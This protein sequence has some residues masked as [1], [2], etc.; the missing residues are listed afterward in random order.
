M[1][2]YKILLTFLIVFLL[3]GTSAV[4][5]WPI[6]QEG[7][8]ATETYTWDAI[9]GVDQLGRNLPI[10]SEVGNPKS[11]RY[12]GMFY[13]LAS[14]IDSG[15]YNIEYIS[16]KYPSAIYNNTDGVWN[17][18]CGHH[19]GEP[20]FG[21]YQ[22]DDTWVIR[23]HM[24]MLASAGVDFIVFDTTNGRTFDGAVKR[25]LEI[26][27]ELHQQGVK[28]PKI[29][30]Y[31]NYQSGIIMDDLYKRYYDANAPARYPDLW[32]YW[33]DKPLIIGQKTEASATV[34][35]FFTVKQSQW[36]NLP[37]EEDGFPWIEFSRD[38]PVHTYNGQPEVMS[39][40]VAQNATFY[41]SDPAFF[42][43]T[44]TWGRSYHDGTYDNTP[45]AVNYGYNFAEQWNQA[46]EEDPPIVFVTQWNEWSAGV[47]DN[48]FT[49]DHYANFYDNCT[50]EYSRDIEPMKDG[51]MDN[52]Y[53]Q[54]A[55]YIR[56]YKGF[57]AMPVP[58]V[59]KT[60]TVGTDFSQWADVSPAYKDYTGDTAARDS[61]GTGAQYY[62]NNTGR[63]DIDVMKVARDAN[64]IY[65][66]V[67]TV[68]SITPYTDA[69]WMRLLI[70][71]DNNPYNGW[72][73][74]DYII[75]RS[76]VGANT[77]ILEQS[78]GGW[79]W[80]TVA[81]NISY[82]VVGNQMQLAIPRSSLGISGDPLNI[83]FKWS[84]NMQSDGDIMDFYANGD[85]APDG[86][87]RYAYY[88]SESTLALP[89]P[90]T[91]PMPSP[92]P[93][94]TLAPIPGVE[95]SW[96]FNNTGDL[97]AW[98]KDEYDVDF[99]NPSASTSTVAIGSTDIAAEK[100]TTTNYFRDFRVFVTSNGNN[101][102]N[103]KLTLYKWNTDYNTTISG[104][105]ITYWTWK[106]FTDNTWISVPWEGQEP[107]DYLWTLS[108]AVENVGVWKAGGSYPGVT[109]YFNGTPV[110]GHY[111]FAITDSNVAHFG[112]NA[113]NA[114]QGSISN[115]NSSIVYKNKINMELTK[116]QKIEIRM[117]NNTSSTSAQLYFNT[118]LGKLVNTWQFVTE[119][120]NWTANGHV[121]GFGWQ[122]GGCIGGNVVGVDPRI[123]SPDNLGTDITNNK[124]VR[125]K[126]K[127]S[128][129]NTTGQ[130]YFTTTGDTAWNEVKSK[131]FT[132]IANDAN[133]TEY[134]IDMST[135]P[136]WTGTL[137]Q[138]WL[139]PNKDVTTGSFSI[140]SISIQKA[141][142]KDWL[143]ASN[144]ENW[145]T[146]T[147]ISGFGWQTGGYVVGN[148]TGGDPAMFSSDNLGIDLTTNKII[149]IKLKNSTSST[150][151]QI[152]FTTNTDNSFSETKS[153]TFTIIANDSQYTEYLVDM[154]FVPGWRGTL[155]QVRFD[156]A[157]DASN[158]SFSLDY[159]E[160]DEP[161]DDTYSKVFTINSNDPN[162]TTYLVDMS[163]VP[164]WTGTLQGLKLKPAVGATSGTF[165]IDYIR[166]RVIPSN[167]SY[168]WEF[169]S[170]TQGWSYHPDI[171]GFGWQTGGY[172]GGDIVG[173]DP[174]MF[175]PDN[176]GTD[177]TDNKLITVRMKNNTSSTTGQ[178]YFITNS[179]PNYNQVMTKTFTIVA[180]DT[181]YRDYII[182]MSNIPGWGGTL[183][184]LRLDPDMNVTSG[185]FSVDYI[186]IGR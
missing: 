100:F 154:S 160:I 13:Y 164:G 143:Y 124:L 175:S 21:F 26:L 90:T 125:V 156:P 102:G 167:T 37:I 149:R 180:N 41:M 84:D 151:G 83:E 85:C 88:T 148:I 171:S 5:N 44:G 133:Y 179:V 157:K 20:L 6:G 50:Q 183:K 104:M 110:S 117:K 153:K 12:V 137:K 147:N 141:A 165:C 18:G 4:T 176:V 142:T 52:Y 78:T 140:D 36:P 48:Y 22:P 53:M 65:F 95:K 112:V 108:G 45:G 25:I 28:V 93:T 89:T 81:T 177:I 63:N 77:T 42:G 127:N 134:V 87:F 97:E 96:E 33:R 14:F 59:Q 136:G 98:G 70:N 155:K 79:N 68:N 107:G 131:T 135:V 138:L 54:L 3:L 29:A 118:D 109:A 24:Q 57:A 158:G 116:N 46:L 145:T 166:L 132:I 1:K 86:R 30:F 67:K 150:L 62:T 181:E 73:G 19:W 129:S 144:T 101:T 182:D 80:S 123:I 9:L 38:L 105:P 82:K 99:Y 130:I 8:S 126:M 15:P 163:D 51:H 120:Q 40:S 139:D 159:I 115:S 162:Y 71:T 16:K 27:Q 39:V 152:Y 49:G 31:T 35:N 174:F 106:D 2:K 72:N 121:S 161:W 92:T 128:T 69:Q 66:Y 23:K 173:T 76:G 60:I 178:I 146:N 75:N 185:S 43:R 58:G 111:M 170:D 10:N 64:N 172:V 184:Q 119:M 34:Q 169:T 32:F 91:L 103:L 56:K 7:V 74:Y 168:S 114:L 61:R 47:Y 11:D 186:T 122:V 55:S 113:E 17:G 94:S